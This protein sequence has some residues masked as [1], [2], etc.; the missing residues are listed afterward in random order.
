MFP[1]KKKKKWKNWSESFLNEPQN[2]LY[3]KCIEDIQNIVNSCRREGKKIRVIG[4]GHSFVPIAATEGVLLSLDNLKGIDQINRK[5]KRVTVW[6]GTTLKDLGLL[7][8]EQGYAMEN[9]GDINSQTIA[10]SISTGTHG[11]G[12]N[13][14]SLSTQITELTVVTADGQILTV[15]ENE[16]NHLFDA[17]RLS[18]GMLGIIVKV[19]IQVIDSHQLVSESRRASTDEILPN[20][21]TLT[22]TNRHFEFFWFPYTRTYQIKTLNSPGAEG[23]TK[24]K[25]KSTFNNMIL[26]NGA[27]WALSELSKNQP[28]M[29]KS[30]SKIIA[31]GIPT[32]KAIG[33]SFD[34]YATPRLVKF[35][36]MEYSVPADK[37]APVLQ[38]I[39]YVIRKNKFKVHFPIECRYVQADNLWLSPSYQRDSAYIAIHMYKGMEYEAYFAAVEE[40][41]RHYDGRPHWGKMHTLTAQ[42]FK[43][44]YPR[45][46]D[47]LHLRKQMDPEDI[48]LNSYLK[49]LFCEDE[50]YKIPVSK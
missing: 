17:A 32:G 23:V 40:V 7:L 27:L 48:L 39:D 26:E 12:I 34:M 37:M 14:G 35:N 16:N 36:E 43:E 28:K 13:Y 24:L 47:F 20:L 8:H 19:E 31:W 42:D 9:L 30:I 6:A 33:N 2:I 44:M 41:F 15:S 3:P 49:E 5:K 4:A 10:G 18:L 25:G 22:T 45:F 38:D 11:S 21:H 29:S 46:N 50:F 1:L